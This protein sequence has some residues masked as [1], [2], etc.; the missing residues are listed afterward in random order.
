MKEPIKCT[1]GTSKLFPE[2]QCERPVVGYLFGDPY[3]KE[4]MDK[5]IEIHR[6]FNGPGISGKC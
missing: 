3:C 1:T 6:K 4:Y 5:L 2:P